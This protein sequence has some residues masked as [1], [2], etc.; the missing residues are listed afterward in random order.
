M[1]VIVT[2]ELTVLQLTATART[3]WHRGKT[4]VL[5][6]LRTRPEA[7][8]IGCGIQWVPVETCLE[9]VGMGLTSYCSWFG[10]RDRRNERLESTSRVAPTGFCAGSGGGG[11]SSLVALPLRCDALLGG[12]GGAGGGGISV[13][14]WRGG[15]GEGL[16]GACTI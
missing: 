14:R 12:G 9:E 16:Q 4:V 13:R 3:G 11:G 10:K 7:I 1:S 5:G 6:R 15:Y 2:E 8:V